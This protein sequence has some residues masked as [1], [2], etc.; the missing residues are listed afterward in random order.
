MWKKIGEW[1]GRDPMTINAKLV[2]GMPVVVI[3]QETGNGAILA[4][5]KVR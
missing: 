5:M 1:D 4:A 2:G 3:V